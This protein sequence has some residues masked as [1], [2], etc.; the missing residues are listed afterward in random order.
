[1]L[2]VAI[3]CGLV[4]IVARL[5]GAPWAAALAAGA[6]A[7]G[8]LAFPRRE[9]AGARGPGPAPAD[10]RSSLLKAVGDSAP[11]AIVVYNDTGRITYANGAAL[12]LFAED[13]PLED[14]NFLRLVQGAPTSLQQALV[15][16]GDALFTVEQAG[17]SATYSLSRRLFDL[18]GE[19]H[20]LLIVKELT[21]EL[22]R[23]E[24]DVWKNVIRI[25]NHELNNSL[26]PIS[27]MVHSAR[28]I[29]QNPEH[30]PKLGRVFDTI[31]ERTQHLA[32]FLEGY[33][34]FARLPKPRPDRVAWPAF[35][36]NLQALF[37]QARFGP[38][39][40]QD[41]WFDAGQ[42]QQTLINLLK[43]AHEASPEAPDVHLTVEMAPDGA[44]S[45]TVADRGSGM[46]DDVLRHALVPFFST[47]AKGTGLGLALCR[48]ILE[49]HRG[50]LRLMRRSGGGME[51]TCWVPGKSTVVAPRTGRL[52]LT[53][54]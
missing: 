6:I 18:A 45:I 48:E 49:A 29:A 42:M 21:P 16:D 2:R 31:E 26:A 39:P 11:M 40:S 37:P 38:A 43:N 32:A 30:L 9:L 14:Q 25:I 52:T 19:R 17:E 22:G 33:A 51:I 46:S 3:A 12:T 7:G 15:R 8:A 41:G 10:Q 36:D 27:S 13:Q 47:K 5:L 34:R 28:L 50:K 53:R 35:L 1:M 44:A 23:Q 20:T 4:I 24:I 54:A